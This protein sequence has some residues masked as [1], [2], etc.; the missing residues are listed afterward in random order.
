L[1]GL[2]MKESKGKANPGLAQKIIR[3]QI[4]WVNKIS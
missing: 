2:V 3:E 4:K 1:V